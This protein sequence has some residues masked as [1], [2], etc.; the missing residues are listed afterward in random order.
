MDKT[1]SVVRTTNTVV[2]ALKKLSK[3]KGGEEPVG[4]KISASKSNFARFANNSRPSK[5]KVK[6]VRKSRIEKV[7]M[8]TRVR[9]RVSSNISNRFHDFASLNILNNLNPLSAV[10]T[11]ALLLLLLFKIKFDIIM[12]IMLDIT[13][14]L[15]KILKAEPFKYALIPDPTILSTISIVKINVNTIL[16]FS[17]IA[18]YFKSIGYLS[19]DN[20][21]VFRM[22]AKAIKLMK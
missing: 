17:I 9:P 2:K 4:S 21:M 14:M 22:I 15:S 6:I 3:L 7:P 1:P 20:T 13:I 19:K 12:S 16:I 18:V 8:S 10:I 11:L 5:V